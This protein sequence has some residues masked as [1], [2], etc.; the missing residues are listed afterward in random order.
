MVKQYT[1]SEKSISSSG[2]VFIF[3]DRELKNKRQPIKPIKDF[4]NNLDA[5]SQQNSLL[6][7][8]KTG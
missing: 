1:D 4:F 3:P 6:I 7:L 2:N 5:H 8:V